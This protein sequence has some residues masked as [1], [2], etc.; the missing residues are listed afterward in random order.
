MFWTLLLA[1]PA[2]APG[3]EERGPPE[4]V[5]DD[6]LEA[7][8]CAQTQGIEARERITV[9]DFSRPSNAV[10]LWVIDPDDGEVVLSSVVAHGE[11]SGGRRATSFSNIEG[12]HQS[13]LGLYG[14]AEIYTGRFGYSMRLDGLEEGL[15]DQARE[16]AIVVHPALNVSRWW[17]GTTLGCFGL[18]PTE[19]RAIIDAS[20]EG[21]WLAWHPEWRDRTH[22]LCERVSVSRR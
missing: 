9:V 12:S 10:R 8:R 21:L 2:A 11:N 16:R 22:L 4:E 14:A 19:S 17:V 6:A 20:T 3:L 13:S 18:A 15:N 5:V 1:C 7:W